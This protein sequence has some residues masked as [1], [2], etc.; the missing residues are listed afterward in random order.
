MEKNAKEIKNSALGGMQNVRSSTLR[1]RESGGGAYAKEIEW[2]AYAADLYIISQCCGVG[3]RR[4]GAV[5]MLL[6]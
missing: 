5:A 4:A 6:F 1:N 3:G 2:P